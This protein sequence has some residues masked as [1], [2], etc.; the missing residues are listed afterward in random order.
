MN[1]QQWGQQQAPN[2]PMGFLGRLM[3]AAGVPPAM[4]PVQNGP[5]M[6][7]VA[8]GVAWEGQQPH[9]QQGQLPVYRPPFVYQGPQP[10]YFAQPQR[11][12]GF[13]AP[14]G[15]WHP[16]PQFPAAQ[17]LNERRPEVP[18]QNTSTGD[19]EAPTAN[20][21]NTSNIGEGR[22]AGP[23]SST[24]LSAREATAAAALRRM[25]PSSSQQVPGVSAQP[26]TPTPTV[27]TTGNSQSTDTSARPM[28][29]TETPRQIHAPALI[30]LSDLGARPRGFYGSP[31][32]RTAGG[33]NGYA[34]PAEG[35][36]DLRD[37]RALPEQLT[38]EQLTRL[39]R[40]TRDALD[41]RLRI[42]ENVQMTTERCIEELLKCRSMLPRDPC[43]PLSQDYYPAGT[44]SQ[45]T[46]GAQGA[47]GSN[48][49]QDS[50]RRADNE[51]PPNQEVEAA[52]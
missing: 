19:E 7:P 46:P 17:P 24:T 42:L 48:N 50:D 43:E 15:V 49:T 14:D 32:M 4:P 47:N 45:P 36:N 23:S 12:Q 2:N 6:Q 11:F 21:S 44:S 52:F 38:N 5:A 26:L 22:E 27:N 37:I 16:W 29:P 25:N 8:N 34:F 13:W 1:A 28:S 35:Y 40:L 20:S 3:G 41:E 18:A 30:P 33:P 51:Q 10:Q 9:G 31:V 39:D